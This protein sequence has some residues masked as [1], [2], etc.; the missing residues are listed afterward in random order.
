VLKT[1]SIRS[2]VSIEHRLVLRLPQVPVIVFWYLSWELLFR[3]FSDD[4]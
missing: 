1:S 4:R 3:C 2:A